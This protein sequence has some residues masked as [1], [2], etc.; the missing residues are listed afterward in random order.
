[1]QPKFT[2]IPSDMRRHLLVQAGL[3]SHLINS[4]DHTYIYLRIE[5]ERESIWTS[6]KDQG[7]RLATKGPQSKH[8]AK[9]TME[10]KLVVVTSIFGHKSAHV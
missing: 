9:G 8:V 3:H 1:M 2:Y 5:R 4:A 7:P 10:T 6:I